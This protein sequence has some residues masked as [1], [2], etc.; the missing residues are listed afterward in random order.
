M[1]RGVLTVLSILVF[2]FLSMISFASAS[3]MACKLGISLINQD[4]Y[5]AVQ[6][7]YVKLVFQVT[8]VDGSNCNDI[9]FNLLPD[10]PI[11]FNPGESGMRTF[12][13]VNYIKDYKSN[14]LIPYKVRIDKNALD[15]TTPVEV[16][17]QSK[18]S[19]PLSKTFN[20][21]L[22]DVRAKF[23]VYVKN[24]NYKTHEMTLEILN[25]GSSD[26]EALTV[27]IAKQNSIQIK[28]ANK[29]IVGDLNSNEYTSAE[30]EAV[31]SNGNF[32]VSLEYSDAI[33]VRRT[34][35]Q[36]VTFD[37]SYF[38]NRKADEKTTSVWIYILY[39]AIALGLAYWFFRRKKK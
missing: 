23:E 28:G 34:V 15:G 25:D 38:I 6:G 27:G 12:S 8:G 39:V 37:S 33:N 30:F 26:I 2:G 35:M 21:K 16:R 36:N 18:Y 24:Y 22:K 29:V 10:Y 20:I 9:T 4:P 19:A 13:R 7:D 11:K 31:P 32:T 5:P 1:K 3:G 14:L 17:V